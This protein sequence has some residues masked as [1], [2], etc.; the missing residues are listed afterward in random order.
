MATVFLAEDLKH[1]RK[2]ALKV[3]KPELAAVLGADRFVQEITTT[4]ALQHPHILPLFDSG[5][6]DGFLYYVMPFI[7]G[8]TLRDKLNRETQLGVADAVKIATDVADALQYAHEHGVIHRDI[9]PENILLANGR[10]MVADFGIALAVSAAAGGR[11]TE[12]GLSLGTP[13]YM[14]PEQATAEKEITGRS[15]IYSLASVLYEMLTG[16]PPHMG[17]SAQQII[18]KI[19]TEPAAPVTKLRKSVPPHVAAAIATALEKL[20]ADRFAS[21]SEFAD[22]L[23]GRRAV[24]SITGRPRSTESARAWS[25]AAGAI[26]VAVAALTLVAWMASH[27]GPVSA[28][29][30]VQFVVTAKDVAQPVYTLTWPATVSPDSRTIVYAGAIGNG[31]FQYYARDVGALESR[32][33]PGTIGASMPLFSADGKWLAF[34]A[35]DGKIKKVSLDGGAPIPLAD[36]SEGNGIAWSPRGTIVV[37]AG[38]KTFG[39]SRV[40][41]NGGALTPLTKPDNASGAALWHVWPVMFADGRT[42]VFAVW[43]G[44]N[45]N[46]QSELAI[47]SLDDGVVHP[48]GVRAARPLGVDGK[49]LV[50][51]TTDGVVMATR[52]DLAHYRTERSPVTLVD[53]IPICPTCNGDGAA[54]LSAGGALS[55]MRGSRR[56]RLVWIGKDHVEK[57]VGATA[58]L[59]RTP[60]LS[61]DAARIAV[62]LEANGRKDI[63]IYQIA[64]NT[65]G[66][67]TTAGDN[68]AP[69]WAPDGRSIQFLS[70]RSGEWS[71]WNQPIDGSGESQRTFSS[72]KGL[73]WGVTVAPDQR[74]V[75]LQSSVRATINL[76]SATI[77]SDSATPLFAGGIHNAWGA[78]FSPSGKS[79]AFVSD[80]AGRPEVFVQ[81]FP[82]PGARVQISA[83]GGYEPMWSRDGLHLY[84]AAGNQ[85]TDATL[86]PEPRVSVASRDSLFSAPFFS[87]TPF[88]LA[89]Y[90]VA[91]DGRFLMIRSND[92][93]FQLVVTLN[94]TTEVAARLGKP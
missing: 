2:V 93:H 73:E 57:D 63:W 75:V 67:L 82:G 43:R 54:N 88:S 25:V 58:A 14:S 46:R 64:T 83:A 44:F 66:K 16:E 13:H 12:T 42:I 4:A 91:R 55:Y 17:N 80:E 28:P 94:W 53:S 87:G 71:V 5:T 30:P 21:A 9:K 65:M 20:P 76:F 40:P 62:E 90:D 74:H 35:Q 18:M 26:A 84:Y 79:V 61:P 11:M 3:L 50:Y 27:R 38:V 33:I 56:M 36:Y 81:P 19:I 92:D 1:K 39:L 37:G 77:G 8:E 31:N 49:N 47:T 10:P 72:S 78:R 70:N 22:T 60:R 15:D 7:D 59:M 45:Q 51:L 24:P 52:L 89:S 23:Q 68:S 85:L 69:E 86:T 32:P 29:R 48:I 41:E 34:Q 6:A